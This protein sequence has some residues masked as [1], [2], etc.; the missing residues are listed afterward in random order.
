[1]S[2]HQTRRRADDE[3]AADAT[4]PGSDEPSVRPDLLAGEVFPA[5]PSQE[6]SRR[7]RESLLS[8]ALSLFAEHGY[9][10][11]T[12]DEIAKRAGVAVGGFYLHFRSKKQLLLVLMNRLLEEVAGPVLAAGD[13]PA[14]FSERL[15]ARLRVERAYAGAYRAWR[16]A[17]LRD[18]SL[19]ALHARIEAW[20]TARI[21]AGLRAETAALR[22]RPDVDIAAF[23]W[24]LSVLLWRAIE[25]PA[26]EREAL[27]DT[28]VALT[29]HTLF[30]D[31]GAQPETSS[32]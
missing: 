8:A 7:A 27:A 17:A 5:P 26:E 32:T 31:L 28:I 16:E 19:A 24:I 10:A 15:R 11:T 9:D 1:V 22:T 4:A 29:E 18:G 23:A 6:R 25:A 20:T 30:E 2:D 21:A 12:V 13:R 3:P 14:R